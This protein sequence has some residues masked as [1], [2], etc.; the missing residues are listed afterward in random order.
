M[1]RSPYYFLAAFLPILMGSGT[2]ATDSVAAG[3]QH[4]TPDTQHPSFDL[5]ITN[6]H[7]MDPETKRDQTGLWVGIRGGA[8]AAISDTALAGRDTGSSQ[9]F[10]VLARTP[11]LDGEYAWVGRAEGDWD[12]VAEGDVIRAVRV[13]E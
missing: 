8:I 3:P 10:V 13:E 11:H 12:A 9:I 5:V 7:V 2:R 6:A 4:P 1:T